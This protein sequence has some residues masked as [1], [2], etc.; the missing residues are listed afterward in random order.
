MIF[1]NISD[2][3]KYN[4]Y[5]M[6]CEMPMPLLFKDIRSDEDNIFPCSVENN[7]LKINILRTTIG[8]LEINIKDNSYHAAKSNKKLSELSMALNAKKIVFIKKCERC[9][10]NVKI[11]TSPLSFNNNGYLGYIKLNLMRFQ[12]DIDKFNRKII[13]NDYINNKTSIVD[14]QLD[15]P[16]FAASFGGYIELP[17]INFDFT[18]K[19]KIVQRI[20][21]LIT[22]S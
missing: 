17:L 16:Y 4:S 12:I 20:N 8:S 18:E 10:F 22:F 5:C 7:H 21:T 3:F 14:I 9:S 2:F 13:S 1:N 19:N 6:F 11:R 15:A